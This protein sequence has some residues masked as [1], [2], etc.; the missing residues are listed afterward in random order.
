MR[1][2]NCHWTALYLN[3]SNEKALSIANEIL[4]LSNTI[5][6]EVKIVSE[7]KSELLNAES[8]NIDTEEPCRV[9]IIGGDGTL[10]NLLRHK[11]AREA[12]LLTI[13]A[14]RRNF[15]FDLDEKSARE[16]FLNFIDGNYVEQKVWGMDA[17][18]DG[19]KSFFLNE[20]L[21]ASDHMKAIS[22]KLSIDNYAV[23]EIRG[24]GIIVSTNTGSTAYSLSAGGPIVDF[25][26]N[27]L[28]LSPLNAID[29]WARPIV[30]D[31]LSKVTLEVE[32]KNANYFAILDG[33]EQLAFPH[34]INIKIY[35]KPITFARV[36]WFRGYE[37]VFK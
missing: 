28:V 13:A 16:G 12:I 29:L 37:K 26:L 31:V 20:L 18:I 22:I 30:A 15:Y 3:P 7:V 11:N 36:K 9:V 33:R 23:Y 35:E 21:V 2:E 14:G 32:G 6:E 4:K 8:V 34:L 19:K 25:H 17:D 10:L 1:T 27:S 5:N 24:D